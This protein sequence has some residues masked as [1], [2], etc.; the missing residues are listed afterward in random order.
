MT[1]V[2]SWRFFLWRHGPI[3]PSWRAERRREREGKGEATGE[4]DR[5]RTR[6]R[7]RGRAGNSILFEKRYIDFLK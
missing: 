3:G 4:G 2:F 5:E 1:L 7:E 6:E